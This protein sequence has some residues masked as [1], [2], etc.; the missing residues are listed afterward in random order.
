MDTPD[1]C[2]E[3]DIILDEYG[4]WVCGHAGP[5]SDEAWPSWYRWCMELSDD[6]YSRYR[7][8][9]GRHTTE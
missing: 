7:K 2:H 4:C 5:I 6:N 9:I 1:L 8:A 3:H